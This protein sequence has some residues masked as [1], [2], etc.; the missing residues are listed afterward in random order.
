MTTKTV[1][2][3]PPG[4]KAITS[5]TEYAYGPSGRLSGIFLPDGSM[6]EYRRNGQGQVIALER[7]RIRTSWLR[8]LQSLEA[9]VKDL[10]R[11]IVGLRA[12]AYGNEVR[13]RYLCSAQGC[14]PG[15]AT[16]HRRARRWPS[17]WHW[18]C[19]PCQAPRRPTQRR[20]TGR[21]TNSRRRRHY[22][23]RLDMSAI[24]GPCWIM[25][26][27]GTPNATC[28]CR[29]PPTGQSAKLMMPK[30]AGSPAPGRST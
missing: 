14:W 24:L 29:K 21:A 28:S 26:I 18:L 12:A 8:W 20:C 16:A 9:I 11:D 5:L 1:T 25:V 2:L 22:R 15:S 27:C 30:I 3:S 13:A 23:A 6:L 17:G 19:L 4:G 10:E 7:H